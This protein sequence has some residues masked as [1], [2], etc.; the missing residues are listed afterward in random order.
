M[1]S[2]RRV[3]IT[4][5]VIIAAGVGYRWW[6][7]DERAIRASLSEIAESLTIPVNEAGLG[8][9]TR[10]AMLRNN[11]APEIE[12]S[13][14][15]SPAE[16]AEASQRIVGRDA[17]L[18]FVGGWSPPPGGMTVEFVDMQVTVDAGRSRAIVK[19][20]A[21]VTSG[22]SEQATV[23]AREVV[24]GFSRIDREWLVTSARLEETLRR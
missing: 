5:V 1:W 6:T 3:L 19:S 2:I 23:D 4:A 12:I 17:A 16:G 7:S 22:T 8:R 14:T 10:V 24:V 21:M 15:A 13:G 11:L 18:A 20:T 9:V